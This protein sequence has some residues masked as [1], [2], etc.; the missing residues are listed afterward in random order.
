[1]PEWQLR[2]VWACWAAVLYG[3]QL[4]GD[5]YGPRDLREWNVSGV[6]A[7]RADVLCEQQLPD[8]RPLRERHLSG[9][10]A[11]RPALLREQQLHPDRH[12]LPERYLSE[13]WYDAGTATTDRDPADHDPTNH[14]ANAA[15]DLFT[16]GHRTADCA[17]G[18]ADGG[19]PTAPTA[20]VAVQRRG[21]A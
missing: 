9:L 19:V 4:P 15:T 5:E 21:R 12:Q 16:T 14:G 6:R 8:R 7:C 20:C 1:M 17:A 10:R 11:S 18:D 3:G 13:P 2:G